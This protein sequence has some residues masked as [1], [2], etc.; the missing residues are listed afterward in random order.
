MPTFA[1]FPQG[2]SQGPRD[3]DSKAHLTLDLRP[4]GCALVVGSLGF[5]PA[6]NHIEIQ[7]AGRPLVADE[8]HGKPLDEHS[9]PIRLM[10]T[11]DQQ[12]SKA[13]GNLPTVGLKSALK[14]MGPRR[15]VS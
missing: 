11:E 5:K 6:A 9:G 15:P 14:A 12:P 7:P 13:L 8:L 10:V 3:T 4:G 2:S 1:S